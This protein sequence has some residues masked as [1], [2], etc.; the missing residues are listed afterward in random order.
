MG[1]NLSTMAIASTR[2]NHDGPATSHLNV[3]AALVEVAVAASPIPEATLETD[4]LDPAVVVMVWFVEGPAGVSPSAS[5]AGE[6]KVAFGFNRSSTE[7]TTPS[8]MAR[9]VLLIPALLTKQSAAGVTETGRFGIAIGIKRD[10]VSENKS[11]KASRRMSL[12]G[13]AINLVWLSTL[14]AP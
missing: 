1:H 3:M 12:L 10:S 7:K 9:L 2:I 13:R 5:L 6:V 4:T 14:E 11:R 8:E